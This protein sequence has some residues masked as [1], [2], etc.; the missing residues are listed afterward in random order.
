MTDTEKLQQI[1]LKAL[2][3]QKRYYEAHKAQI[4]QK[5]KGDRDQL[6]IINTPIPEVII[7][8]AFTLEMVLEVISKI[9][10]ENTRKKY[11]ADLKRVFTLAKLDI[12][13]GSM[14]EFN[15]IK[16]AVCESKYSLSTQRG[17]I[18]SLLV[19]IDHSKI[20]IDKKHDML[21]FW[22]WQR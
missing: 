19:F 13:V 7:P 17:S 22:T 20:V 10:T 12:F 15:T 1:K 9:E 21:Y 2:E 6:K 5:K 18:Q 11:T 3:R 4:L 8:T 16:K 14:E